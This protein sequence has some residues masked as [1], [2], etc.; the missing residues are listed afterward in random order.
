MKKIWS[1][2]KEDVLF[3]V[4]LV[5]IFL[6][7]N[8]TLFPA[9]VVGSSMYPNLVEGEFGIS[10]KITAKFKVNRFDTVVVNYKDENKDLVKRVIGMPNETIKYVDNTLYIDGEKYDEEFLQDVTTNDFEVTL[11]ESEYFVMGDNR[12]VSKDSRADGPFKKDDIIATH[13][14]V[15]YPFKEFRFVK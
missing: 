14:L 4:E 2:I 15:I 3:L 8:A 13:F 6:I 9:Q 12:N 11:G 1:S 5:V 10:F 7:L